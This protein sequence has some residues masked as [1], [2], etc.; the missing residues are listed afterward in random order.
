[1]TAEMRTYKL[2]GTHAHDEFNRYSRNVRVRCSSSL[3]LTRMT[4]MG[5]LCQSSVPPYA[6]T[7][8]CVLLFAMFVH[9]ILR[10]YTERVCKSSMRFT[11]LTQS[12]C[13]VFCKFSRIPSMMF[14]LHPIGLN[15]FSWCNFFQ[16]PAL[17]FPSMKCTLGRCLMQSTTEEWSATTCLLTLI[18]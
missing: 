6:C 18:K 3:F 10:S 1:M 9:A 14:F 5:P 12:R 2:L 4:E 15:G 17:A 13:P 16:V 11:D 7:L 8:Y